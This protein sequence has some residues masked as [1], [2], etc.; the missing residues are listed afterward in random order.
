MATYIGCKPRKCEYMS[1]RRDCDGDSA[2]YCLLN[3]YCCYQR[4]VRDCDGDTVT[5]C[6]KEG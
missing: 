5:M 2:A 6:E 3:G 1:I 4:D